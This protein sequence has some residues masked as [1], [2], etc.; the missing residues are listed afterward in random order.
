MLLTAE[1]KF[2][3]DDVDAEPGVQLIWQG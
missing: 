2:V 3:V 1:G